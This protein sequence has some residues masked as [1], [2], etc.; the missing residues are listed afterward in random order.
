MLVASPQR[1]LYQSKPKAIDPSAT[2]QITRIAAELSRATKLVERYRKEAR[3]AAK[4]LHAQEGELKTA[5]KRIAELERLLN[6]K[7]KGRG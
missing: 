6:L 1:A 2:A 3:T 4:K 5:N 7:K